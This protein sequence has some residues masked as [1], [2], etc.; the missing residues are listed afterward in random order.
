MYN[1]KNTLFKNP[2]ANISNRLIAMEHMVAGF[3]GTIPAKSAKIRF[4]YL[5]G[6]GWFGYGFKH[7]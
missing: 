6:R 2:D 3:K 5:L 4:A 7:L 1:N